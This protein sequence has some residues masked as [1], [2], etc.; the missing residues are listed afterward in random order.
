MNADLYTLSL[1]SYAIMR[2]STRV[3][4]NGIPMVIS[5]PDKKA[6]KKFIERK[7]NGAIKC[8]NVVN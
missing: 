8:G 4:K 3:E 2:V 5:F 6:L 7:E 1:V